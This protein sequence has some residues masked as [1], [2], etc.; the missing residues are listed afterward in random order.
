MKLEVM[1]EVA[2]VIKEIAPVI[3]KHGYMVCGIEDS[4][5]TS[6][7]YVSIKILPKPEPG[8]SKDKIMRG[9]GF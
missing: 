2:E 9:E 8:S 5:N 3:E 7:D 6:W 4:G 1:Q